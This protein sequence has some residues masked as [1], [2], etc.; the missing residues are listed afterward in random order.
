ME[1][2]VVA[3]ADVDVLAHPE[4]RVS[5]AQLR[6]AQPL[7]DRGGRTGGGAGGLLEAEVPVAVEGELVEQRLGEAVVVVAGDDRHLALTQRGAQLLEERPRR[8]QRGADGEVAQLDHVAQQDDTVGVADL[9]EQQ[10]P[11]LGVAQHVLA[12][13]RAEV[14]VGDDRRAH[15]SL[16]LD[17]G[18]LVSLWVTNA[19]RPRDWLRS[20]SR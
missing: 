12:A 10:P 1:I 20:Q 13:R 18:R 9:L 19:L 5:D 2:H 16:L 11:H 17:R 6:R 7:V 3:V 4:A 14:E 8:R 15:P